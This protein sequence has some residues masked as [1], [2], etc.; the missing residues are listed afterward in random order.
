MLLFHATILRLG[1]ITSKQCQSCKDKDSIKE[2]NIFPHDSFQTIQ[3][4]LLRRRL[5]LKFRYARSEVKT[6]FTSKK[7]IMLI[8]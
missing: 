3:I 6:L 4:L 7:I 8:L 1:S 5:K 2:V